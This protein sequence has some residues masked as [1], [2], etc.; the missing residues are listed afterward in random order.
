VKKGGRW[1]KIL[2]RT[3]KL[4]LVWFLLH[5][6]LISFDGLTDDTAVADVA[7]VFGTTVHENGEL[8]QRL[9]ARLD[10]AF[11]LYSDQK[12]QMLV[13]SGG[14]GKEGFWEG[15][16]MRDYLLEN[17]CPPKVIL[18]DN[19]GNTTGLTAKNVQEMASKREWKEVYLV[20]QFFHL[21]RAK[22]AFRKLGFPKIY[23]ASPPY[24]EWRDLYSTVREFPAYYVYWLKS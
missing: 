10:R 2:R 13:V 7:V 19:Q 17:G 22:M 20:S 11:Q 8:S 5:T 1:R 16:K 4:G 3:F 14:L 12:V 18:V 24:F 15:D 23:S 9:K 21:S 6:F